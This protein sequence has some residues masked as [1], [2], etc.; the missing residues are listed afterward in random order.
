MSAPASAISPAQ[1]AQATAGLAAFESMLASFPYPLPPANTDRLAADTG[2]Q[3]RYFEWGAAGAGAAAA[4]SDGD[5]RMA[6]A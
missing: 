2:G 5:A 1:Q 3:G 6:G 4:V